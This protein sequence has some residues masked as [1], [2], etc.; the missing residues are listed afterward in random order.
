[1]DDDGIMR[2][3][4]PSPTPDL[5]VPYPEYFQDVRL[6]RLASENATCKRA[7][8]NRLVILEMKMEM[9]RCVCG[10]GGGARKPGTAHQWIGRASLLP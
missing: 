5:P 1:M 2:W 6:V 7:C 4:N 3:R 8:R 10:G 9:H